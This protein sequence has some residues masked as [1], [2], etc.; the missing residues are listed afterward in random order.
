MFFLNRTSV[1]VL[2]SGLACTVIAESKADSLR[3]VSMTIDK[4][5]V[6]L[7]FDLSHIQQSCGLQINW[8]DS[9]STQIRVGRDV[10]ENDFSVDHTYASDGSYPIKIEGK[11]IFR[12]LGT[13]PPCPGEFLTTGV[14]EYQ[15][16]IAEQRERELNEAREAKAKREV[17][18]AKLRLE[19][20]A[21]AK[22]EAEQRAE[23]ARREALELQAELERERLERQKAE[24]AAAAAEAEKRAEEARREALEL[25]AKLERERLERQKAEAAAAVAEEARAERD[26]REREAALDELAKQ[27][28]ELEDLKRQLQLELGK[29]REDSGSIDRLPKTDSY[30][31]S[32][33][34]DDVASEE[35]AE[36]TEPAEVLNNVGGRS[37]LEESELTARTEQQTPARPK[38]EKA[39]TIV[40]A[41]LQGK[42][43][44]GCSDLATQGKA[45]LLELGDGMDF[46]QLP[47]M[48]VN[49]QICLSA[50]TASAK[51]DKG[52]YSIVEFGNGALRCNQYTVGARAMTEDLKAKSYVIAGQFKQVEDDKLVLIDCIIVLSGLDG[53]I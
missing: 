31:D 36:E 53:S 43:L 12:G 16:T 42:F 32:K 33:S 30:D 49:E 17:A 19:Q 51:S 50:L 23:E 5:T 41:E 37:S 40:E 25:Q 10:D 6:N 24:T 34:E 26:R 9:V 39:V 3:P 27:R 28:Q 20:E 18:A 45:I 7:R 11:T 15:R 13:V 29:A 46:S 52:L 21:L 4:S 35:V 22:A 8:G 14:I 1:A 2:I 48:Q 44:K 38:S 47:E